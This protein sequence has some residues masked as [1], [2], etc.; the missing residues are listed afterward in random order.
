MPAP[1]KPLITPEIRATKINREHILTLRHNFIMK[2]ERNIT[3][4]KI[5]G[6]SADFYSFN[7]VE[8]RVM[9]HLKCYKTKDFRMPKKNIVKRIN[10]MLYS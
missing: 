8:H 9:H 6:L 10:V 7:E 1:K 3:A 5:S 2:I 4:F